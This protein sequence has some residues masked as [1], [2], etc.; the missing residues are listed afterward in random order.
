MGESSAQQYEKAMEL[1]KENKYTEAGRSFAALGTYADSPRYTMYCNAI[2]AGEAGL[3]SVAVEN[4]NSLSGFLDSNLLAIY[5]AGLSWEAA[6]DYECA[7][8]V[9]SGITLY[10]DVATRMAGYPALIEARDAAAA[11]QARADAYA[12]ADRAEQNGDYAAAYEGFSN[13]GDY[14]DS[15]ARAAAVQ[16]KGK[17]AQAMQY[18]MQGKF[19]AAHSLFEELENYE[20][21]ALKA[22]I[23]SVTAFAA[24]EDRGNGIAAF[25]LHDAWGI[26]NVNDNIILSPL[27]DS[28]GSFDSLGLARVSRNDKYGYI[29]TQG[30]AIIACEWDEVSAFSGSLCT[31]RLN[32]S[33]GLVD[34][35]GRVVSDA[36]WQTL[37]DSRK[38]SYSLYYMY[39]PS[40]SEEKI[41]VQ[42]SDGKWGFI[43]TDGKL[44][45]EVAWDEIQDFSEGLAA[46]SQNK[47]FGFIDKEGQ[48]VIQPQYTAVRS[49]HEGL[50]AVQDG[51]E[52][53][54]I[55]AKN[56]TVIPARYSQA[57][58]FSDGKADVFLPGTGWQVIDKEGS[59]VYFI[60]SEMVTDYNLAVK[61]EEAGELEQAFALFSGMDYKDSAERAR[62][63]L[64]N[65]GTKKREAQDWE[66]AVQAFEQAESYGDAATQITETRYQQAASLNKAGKYEEA[67]AIYAAIAG[68][69]DVDSIVKT[70]ENIADVA[71]NAA[72]AAAR[73]AMIASCK[74]AGS[75]VTFG[76]YPQTSSGTDSTPIEWMVLDYDA[77]NNRA[78]LISRYGL[79]A[80]P[81]N[82]KSVE[83]TWE[84][85]TLRT[86]LNSTFYNKAFS[87]SEQSAILPTNVDNSSSQGF[88]LYSTSGG[89]NTQD[90]I[91][92]LSVE[93]AYKYFNVQYSVSNNTKANN[94]KSRVQP[95]AY[96]IEQGAYI[97][98]GSKTAEGTAAGIWWLRSP[99]SV[100]DSAAF[101]NYDGS[102]L[103][104]YVYF[105]SCAVRPVFWLALN[106][107]IF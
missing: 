17:Y 31:V 43:D 49:F 2:A 96:A 47:K 58:D 102:L 62:K 77:A 89:N 12:A 98:N 36:Q 10:R 7:S 81:Y 51:G 72:A 1:L 87:T 4:L 94:T 78:L 59:L 91:F 88:S 71:A 55:N 38:G 83:I 52:W 5:Y 93:E 29:N 6:E 56:E 65:L 106:A 85:C 3:Y 25:K 8:K 68:Y 86:W 11:E 24:V 105:A 66:G 23:L 80:Q 19:S 53:K 9:L 84:K 21:S 26:L 35:Q 42:D 41:K 13:L 101:V 95:T 76:T 46:V 73:E 79:D 27:W 32:G 100:Q 44:V 48:I 63:V 14:R 74:K 39:A 18:A 57:L 45:G 97:S 15:A 20:D 30:E 82:E 70:D 50:A 54:Y 75:Y 90:K 37:G 34:A 103:S 104:C 60:S 33:F 28:I 40:L 99:G 107:D 16:D 61:L 64:Y 69:K 67:Y 92:L 22:Y